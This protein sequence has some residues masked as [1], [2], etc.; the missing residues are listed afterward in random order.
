MKEKQKNVIDVPRIRATHTL[1]KDNPTNELDI[2]YF[3]LMWWHFCTQNQRT[4]KKLTTHRYIGIGKV[5]CLKKLDLITKMY[6]NRG[7]TISTYNG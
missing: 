1:V 3:H 2:D 4:L 5:E 6:S 7:F